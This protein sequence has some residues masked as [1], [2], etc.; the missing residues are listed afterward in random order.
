MTN[1]TPSPF[2]EKVSGAVTDALS[3]ALE[4]QSPSL[5]AAKKYQERF[6]SKNRIYSNNRVYISP[7]MFSMLTKM[8]AVV[9]KEKTSI[10]G[11]LTEIVREHMERHRDSINAIYLTNTQPLF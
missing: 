3:D 6:L 2:M 4:R 9:G 7:E 11:Y 8:V 5:A 10:G 1:N